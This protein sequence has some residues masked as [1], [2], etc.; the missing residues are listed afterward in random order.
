[1]AKLIIEI[2]DLLLSQ[3]LSKSQS[4][5]IS[6]DNFIDEALRRILPEINLPDEIT[7]IINKMLLEAVNRANNKNKGDKFILKSLFS[8]EE[9]QTLATTANKHALGRLFRRKIEAQQNVT[10]LEQRQGTIAVYEKLM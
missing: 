5:Q 2:D 10:L 8:E 3:A 1:M 7:A 4:E 9:W 6:L